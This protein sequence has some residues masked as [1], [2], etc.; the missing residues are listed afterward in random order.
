MKFFV[1]GADDNEKTEEIYTAT[2]KF[3][4]S[5]CGPITDRKI[6]N[7]TFKD[8]GK[9]VHAEVG[10][11]EPITGETVVAILEANTYLICTPNRGVLK[12]IPILVG[13]HEVISTTDFDK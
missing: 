13:K 1:P 9:I 2:K 3:A 8:H 5:N 6:Q 12:G 10:Q 7:L 11:I 4:I